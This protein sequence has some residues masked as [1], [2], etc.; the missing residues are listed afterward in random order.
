MPKIRKVKP[1]NKEAL[2]SLGYGW[3]TDEDGEYFAFDELVEV[4]SLEAQAYYKAAKDVY[5]MYEKA[6][7]YVVE[8]SLF[9][10]LDI[11]KNMVDYIKYSWKSE[12]HLHL[13][14]RFDFSGGIDAKDIKLIEFNSDTPTLL[15]ETAIAQFMM[16]KDDE[17]QFNS[18][19][20]KISQKIKRII[21]QDE[22][23]VPKFLFSCVKDISEEELTTKFL[24]KIAVDAGAVANFEFMEDLLFNEDIIDKNKNSYDIWFKL[25]PWEELSLE[26]DEI[27]AVLSSSK[28]FKTINPAYTLLYQSKGMLK[29]L[30]DLFPDSPYLLKSSFTALEEKYVKKPCFGREGANIEIVDADKKV[31]LS[32]DGIYDNFKVVYQEYVDFVRDEKGRYYQAGVFFSDEPCGLSFRRGEEILDDMSEFIG[33]IVI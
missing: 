25:F 10:D 3:H 27:L 22:N 32:T 8:N 28:S 13:Y 14:G 33:H 15:F 30:Y 26:H 7:E 16:L 18:V 20:E 31:L 19:Y 5:E 4:S 24:Q 21:K 1:I 6:A 2:N 9:E 17:Q 23:L 29:V 12:R 11:E